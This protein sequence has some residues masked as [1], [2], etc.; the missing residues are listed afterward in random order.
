LTGLITVWCSFERNF[1][2]IDFYEIILILSPVGSLCKAGF[3]AQS[4][5]GKSF[6]KTVDSP[7]LGQ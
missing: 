4:N 3:K 5:E 2:A 6:Y 1:Y 7:Y